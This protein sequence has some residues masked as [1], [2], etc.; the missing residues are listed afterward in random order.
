MTKAKGKSKRYNLLNRWPKQKVEVM[1]K[2]KGR[3]KRYNLLNRWP[4]Q[5]VEVKGIIY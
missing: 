4:K 2:A 5:K 1:T 3:S